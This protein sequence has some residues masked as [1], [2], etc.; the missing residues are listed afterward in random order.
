MSPAA[1]Y[2]FNSTNT[3]I[4]RIFNLTG[5]FYHCSKQKFNYKGYDTKAYNPLLKHYFSKYI[6][7][8]E[9]K[10]NTCIIFLLANKKYEKKSEHKNVVRAILSANAC[11]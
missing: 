9:S 2:L 5:N 11:E 3:I 10:Y 8:Q 1:V 4:I 6:N 7:A